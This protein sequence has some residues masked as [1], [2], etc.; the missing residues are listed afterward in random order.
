MFAKKP[1]GARRLAMLAS[2]VA[3]GSAPVVAQT[4]EP[5][6][7]PRQFQQ[8][9]SLALRPP[10]PLIHRQLIGTGF[11]VDET[12]YMLTAAHV[13]VNCVQV[14]VTKEHH[15]VSARLVAETP[16]SDLALLKIPRTLGL[17]AVFPKSITAAPNDMVF[18]GAHDTLPSPQLDA[19]VLANATVTGW[20]EDG[21]LALLSP[22][23]PGASGAP[24]LDWLGLI[25]G[26][27]SRRT[28]SDRVLAV[29]AA[30][31]KAFLQAHGVRITQD[32][33]PQL[34]NAASR[35]HRAASISA[36]VTCLQD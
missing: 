11:F 33:R 26:V 34:E 35:S 28:A 17:A 36:R 27:I 8:S 31:A 15:R 19:D 3:G 30:T 18:A 4:P 12:G 29:S 22:V 32:D 25:Q 14:L 13:V 20:G 1:M 7:L 23:K 2:L 16:A 9:K 6:P 5:S 10:S 24:V 21:A